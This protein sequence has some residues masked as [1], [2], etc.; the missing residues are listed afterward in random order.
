MIDSVLE[1]SIAAARQALLDTVDSAGDHVRVESHD[2][3]TATHFFQCTAAGMELGGDNH[4]GSR[5]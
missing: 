4:S 1:N 3:G 2:P 5:Q